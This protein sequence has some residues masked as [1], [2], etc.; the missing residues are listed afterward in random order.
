M[1]SGRLF[2]ALGMWM[3]LGSGWAQAADISGAIAATLTIT[4]NSRLVGDVTCTVTGA[5]CI[6]FGASGITLA[7]NGYSMTG[8]GDPVT[9]CAGSSAAGEIGIDVNALRDIVIRGPGAVERFRN[10]GIR[11]NNAT[12]VL[13]TGV[14]TST[15]CLSGIFVPGGSGNVLEGNVS[16]RNGHLTNPCGGI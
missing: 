12:G 11:L 9:G 15:N 8:L 13:V 7:L 10:H 4:E 1:K 5:P 14:T 3:L 2:T 6:A 16:V